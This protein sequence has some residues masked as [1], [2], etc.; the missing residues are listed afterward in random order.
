[1]PAIDTNMLAAMRAAIAE[2]LP[3]TCTINAM[4]ETSDG[5]GGITVAGS[6]IATAVACRMDTKQGREI[7]SGGAVQA[8]ISYML[9]IPYD[10][11]MQEDY[12]VVHNN[13]TYA[14]KSINTD[15]S[16]IAVKRVD[17]ERL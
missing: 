8:F 2:L 13:I 3:D 9:S 6:A 17:L 15:Q 11:A 16:W 12:Q 1:M 7:V 10:Q 4:V 5:E 14:V